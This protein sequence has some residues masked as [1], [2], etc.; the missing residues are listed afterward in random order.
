MGGTSVPMLCVQIAATRH[1]S[2]GTEVPP[3]R[4]PSHKRLATLIPTARGFAR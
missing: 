2:V 1:K 3:T 4:E